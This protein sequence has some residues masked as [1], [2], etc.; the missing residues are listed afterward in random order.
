ML[1]IAICDDDEYDR[2][3]VWKIVSGVLAQNQIR[4]EIVQYQN[5]AYLLDELIQKKYDLILLDIQMPEMSGFIAAEQIYS[6]TGGDNLIFVSN[7]EDMVFQSLQFRPFRFVRKSQLKQDLTIAIN[8]W[9]EKNLYDEYIEIKFNSGKVTVPLNEI[10]YMEVKSHILYIHTLKGEQTFRGNL[11]DYVY[12]TEKNGF[13]RPH[14]SYLCNLKYVYEVERENV[15]MS[16]GE[17]IH[18]SR[19]RFD[20][21]KKR[22]LKYI[23]KR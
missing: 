6:M 7:E 5:G 18:I 21:C 2:S 16:N 19:G 14:H 3:A 4:S 8:N 17:R 15:V 13:L 11:S 10:I 1:K 22:Y 12:L 20:E 23:R 9:I